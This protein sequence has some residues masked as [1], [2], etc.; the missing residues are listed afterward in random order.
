MALRIFFLVNNN[1]YDDKFADVSKGSVVWLSL[2]WSQKLHGNLRRLIE[3]SRA[4]GRTWRANNA[5]SVDFIILSF[6]RTRRMREKTHFGTTLTIQARKT[7]VTEII[8]CLWF[9]ISRNLIFRIRGRRGIDDIQGS[10]FELLRLRETVSWVKAF[11]LFILNWSTY[12][13]GSTLSDDFVNISS[14][15]VGL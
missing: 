6:Q 4:C 15:S 11:N 1:N 2:H 14:E 12:T 7:N 3:I 5:L 13:L 10:Y 9:Y 8:S